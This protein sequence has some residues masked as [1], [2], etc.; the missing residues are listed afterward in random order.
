MLAHARL[1]DPEGV[2]EREREMRE[3]ERVEWEGGLSV[4][5]TGGG[6]E[7]EGESSADDMS[8]DG[9]GDVNGE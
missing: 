1:Q 9:K 2:E 3:L 5:A 4:A 6:S 8:V 7:G